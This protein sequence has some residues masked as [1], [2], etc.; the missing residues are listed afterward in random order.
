MLLLNPEMSLLCLQALLPPGIAI[1]VLHKRARRVSAGLLMM[2]KDSR[3]GGRRWS[4][5][6]SSRRRRRKRNILVMT[7][8][9][10]AITR[11]SRG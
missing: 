3:R 9:R 8:S 2:P 10:A 4:R 11:M 5:R 7:C 6:S 1:P